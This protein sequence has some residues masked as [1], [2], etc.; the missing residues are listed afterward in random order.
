MILGVVADHPVVLAAK[1]KFGL[2]LGFAGN[3][4]ISRHFHFLSSRLG[5]STF[6]GN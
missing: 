1:Y 5:N 6:C 4:Y 2:G 3:L